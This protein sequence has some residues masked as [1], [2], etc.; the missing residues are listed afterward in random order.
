MVERRLKW[1]ITGGCGFIGTSLIKKL[2]EE[3][4]ASAIRVVDNLSVGNR[5]DLGHVSSFF[6]TDITEVGPIAPHRQVELVSADI[7]DRR[8]A[9]AVTQGAE[10]VV[11]LAANTG[12][13]P[14]IENPIED[15][16]TNVM[17]TVHYLEACRRHKVDAF[18]LASSGAPIGTAT[19]PIHEEMACHPISP[20]GA[21]KLAGEAY[22]SAYYGSYGLKTVALRFS[23]V[24]GPLSDHKNSVVAR[25]INQAIK[26]E[27][28]IINGDGSQTR[29]FLYIDDLI[30][31][32]L[33]TVATLHGGEVFQIATGEETSIKEMA[34]ILAEHLA[35]N[36]GRRPAIRYG[37]P[38]CGEVSRNFSDIS[39]ARQMLGWAPRVQLREGLLRTVNWFISPKV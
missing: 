20:Y 17:G 34:G 32:I 33:K 37:E 1:L 2:Q 3:G 36:T 9:L 5:N 39:K 12:V 22:C 27:T 13:Q 4:L 19:P 14:S 35:A 18:I 26:G 15:M 29:D 7:R 25:F 11:H 10:V 28:W 6:E 24:Y 31:A 16:E 21:S 30:A 8:A 23:N 38:L